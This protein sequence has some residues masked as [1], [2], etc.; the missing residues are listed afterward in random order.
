MTMNPMYKKFLALNDFID[1]N[2]SKLSREDYEYLVE[3]LGNLTDQ[4]IGREID[5]LE[6]LGE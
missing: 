5:I 2:Y 6:S 3:V 4:V 1:T